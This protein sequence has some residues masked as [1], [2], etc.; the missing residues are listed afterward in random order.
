MRRVHPAWE[1]S[2]CQI[3][4][5]VI[6][7]IEARRKRALHVRCELAGL[8]KLGVMAVVQEYSWIEEHLCSSQFWSRW[9][10][11]GVGARE[12][13]IDVLA[14]RQRTEI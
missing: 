1:T 3:R 8:G 14:C 2:D 7:R 12:A 11:P 4:G 13:W 9:A 6:R 10:P 5:E